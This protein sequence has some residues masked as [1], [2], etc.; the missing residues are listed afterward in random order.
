ML[1]QVDAAHAAGAEAFEHLVLADGEAAPLALQELLGLEVGQQ[2]VADQQAGEL[3]RLG[4]KAPA[5]RSLSR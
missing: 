5:A 1:A 3:A 2:A 4:G